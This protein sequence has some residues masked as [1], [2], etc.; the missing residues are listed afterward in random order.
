MKG[1]GGM[2]GIKGGIENSKEKSAW[3]GAKKQE[4][5][6]VQRKCLAHPGPTRGLEQKKREWDRK[7][8]QTL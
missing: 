7:K 6:W 3:V 4:E 5:T 8:T 2:S 1:S